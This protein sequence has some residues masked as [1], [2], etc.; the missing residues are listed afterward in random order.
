MENS[1]LRPVW[2]KVFRLDII[3]I[4]IM[5]VLLGIIRVTGLYREEIYLVVFG[6]LI[7]WVLPVIFFSK[8]GRRIIG[9]KKPGLW[10]WLPLSFLLG[11][12][13]AVAFYFL[14]YLLFGTGIENWGM[15]VAREFSGQEE[16][17]IPA[18]FAVVTL[19][20]MLF[21]P[22]G[23]EL[24]FRGMVQEVLH[25][26]LSSYKLAGFWSSFLFA[27]IHL[28]H[29]EIFFSGLGFFSILIPLAIWFILM[30]LVS[31]LFIFARVKSGSIFGAIACHSG[32]ILGMNLFVYHVLIP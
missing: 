12:I 24:F 10:L 18:V 5:F 28:P 27:A 22:I 32:F 25:E 31:K 17:L 7:M 8:N 3:F 2:Q 26:R 9:I 29:H 15:T 16:I 13:A 23:E 20:S 6:F 1:L 11:I 30:F 21:S 4:T 19:F 14:G